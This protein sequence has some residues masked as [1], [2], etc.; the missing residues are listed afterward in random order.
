MSNLNRLET[1]QRILRLLVKDN[2]AGS[3]RFAQK[4]MSYWAGNP[5]QIG[6]RFC[7]RVRLNQNIFASL[8]DW[9]AWNGWESGIAALRYASVCDVSWS[10]WRVATR[11]E[12]G[13][14]KCRPAASS[15][16]T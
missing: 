3:S 4:V 8:I 6:A 15:R 11:L 2:C 7:S 14:P 5:E 1:G 9:L 13:R 12:T 10:N 16:V